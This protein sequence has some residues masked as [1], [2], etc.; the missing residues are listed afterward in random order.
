MSLQIMRAAVLI[1]ALRVFV[2]CKPDPDKYLF[3]SSPSEKTISY[4]RLPAARPMFGRGAPKWQLETLMT[5]QNSITPAGLAVDQKRRILYVAAPSVKKVF[6]YRI[7]FENGKAIAVDEFTAAEDVETHWVACDGVGSLFFTDEL[8]GQVFKVDATVLNRATNLIDTTLSKQVIY[9]S[10]SSSKVS[11]PGGIAVDN[12]NVYWGNKALGTQA[13]SVVKSFELPRIRDDPES[14]RA[15]ASN[16]DQVQGVCLVEDNVFFS[17][18]E[19]VLYAVDK[20]GV[21]QATEV[22]SGF[23][24]PR[25][26]SWD[27]DGTVFVADHKAHAVLSFAGNMQTPGTA[28]VATLV[29]VTKPFDV[30]VMSRSRLKAVS[31]ILLLAGFFMQNM[32]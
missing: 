14:I 23:Q 21:Q 17:A 13:G 15:V 3:I 2:W 31:K 25:G 18:H 22:H 9:A 8:G 12:Y 16:I 10:S 6:G 30:A 5:L 26:C 7:K 24:S 20:A 11:S 1:E 29:N 19:Q 32:F 28:R 4:V 27:G